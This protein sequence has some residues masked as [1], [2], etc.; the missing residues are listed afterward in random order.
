MVC[1]KI[2]F[3]HEYGAP[4]HICALEFLCKKNNIQLQQREL[5]ILHQ[6]GSCIKNFNFLKLKRMLNNV[7]F[8][9]NL[10]FS[11]NKKI[12]L[13]IA[14]YN[15]KLYYL[16]FVLRNHFVYYF[17]SYTCWDQTCM[18]HK[19][20]YSRSLLYKWRVF[21]SQKVMHIFAVSNKVRDELVRNGF[22]EK[23][24]ITV[25]Y[26][27]LK[28]KYTALNVK[29]NVNFIYSGRLV[30]EKGIEELLEYFKKNNKFNLYIVG[31][32]NLKDFVLKECSDYSNIKYCGYINNKEELYKLYNNCSYFVLN[33]KKNNGWE[34]LFGISIIEAMLCGAIPVSVSHAGPME[35]IED[36]INGFLF[37]E[38]QLSDAISRVV[39][40]SDVEYYTI[41]DTA[42][43]SAKKYYDSNISKRWSSVLNE[44]K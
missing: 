30:K 14:P 40:I 28:K 36:N 7:L 21:L 9:F 23:E 43:C 15:Y 24:K 37:D 2:Y 11:S 18:A 39:M 10:L 26:H 29:R 44:L 38:G 17:T 34:E 31:K 42:I 41:K 22:S 33:S 4:S 20:L 5:N 12:V 8:I 35:I 13:G 16:D 3:L 27:S 25:V 19:F 6:L 32:G 1:D